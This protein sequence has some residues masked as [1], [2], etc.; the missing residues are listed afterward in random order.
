MSAIITS[1]DDLSKGIFGGGIRVKTNRPGTVE[2]TP[3]YPGI[4]DYIRELLDIFE[5]PEEPNT[6]RVYD[7]T[8]QQISLL[9]TFFTVGHCGMW[10]QPTRLV[11]EW[12]VKTDDLNL[13]TKAGRDERDARRAR[14]IAES[15]SLLGKIKA[16][17]TPE[18]IE[19]VSKQ[20]QKERLEYDVLIPTGKKHARELMSNELDALLKKMDRGGYYTSTPVKVCFWKTPS[21]VLHIERV[22]TEN[23]N[24]STVVST[25]GLTS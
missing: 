20:E 19:Q 25:D 17:M 7:P 22:T 21:D 8:R 16:L 10:R 13:R 5:T 6:Y 4:S 24:E 18:F 11:W 23:L 2:Y 12:I 14:M 3:T 9:N 15:L 1:I